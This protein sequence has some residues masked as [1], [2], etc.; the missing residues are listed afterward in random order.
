MRRWLLT[1]IPT[2]VLVLASL[3]G[4]ADTWD[5]E[6][7]STLPGVT[8]Q[9]SNREGD[10]LQRTYSVLDAQGTYQGVRSELKRRGWAIARAAQVNGQLP[11]LALQASKGGASLDL[12]VNAVPGLG[13]NMAV[14]VSMPTPTTRPDKEP[15][16]QSE[17]EHVS[18]DLV[19]NDSGV[20]RS[21][22]LEGGEVVINGSSCHLM[23]SGHCSQLTLNG[24][25][26]Q[27]SARRLDLVTINGSSNKVTWTT[28]DNQAA[29][30]VTDNGSGNHVAGR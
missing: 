13:G 14:R 9:A 8:L 29:P 19:I 7:L 4:A 21:Y 6:W 22:H 26:N 11:V 15:A 2:L 12:S 27:V 16:A 23:L 18:G 30:H 24:S 10:G 20:H 1:L 25:G 28:R 3:A 17:V 5:L